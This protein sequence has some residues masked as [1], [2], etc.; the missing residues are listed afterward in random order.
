MIRWMMPLA[1]AG[2]LVACNTGDSIFEW[3]EETAAM[4][5]AQEAEAGGHARVGEDAASEIAQAAPAAM[6]EGATATP[7]VIVA[8]DGSPTEGTLLR[9]ASGTRSNQIEV[10]WSSGTACTGGLVEQAA[11][12]EAGAGGAGTMALNCTDG[13][14]WIGDYVAT[15][16]GRGAWTLRNGSG[17]TAR[18]LYGDDVAADPAAFDALWA[19]RGTGG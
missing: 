15:D 1:I 10:R 9:N 13:T 7:I 4:L 2:L 6:P 12:D 14:V 18:A 16:A 11:A 5:A 17:T 3:D 8:A 19:A